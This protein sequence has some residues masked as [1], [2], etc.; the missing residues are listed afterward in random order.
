METNR[1]IF[2]KHDQATIDQ[3]DRCLA[4]ERAIAGA[5]CADGHLGYSMP[6]GGVVAYKDAVSPSGVGFDIA[7]GNK[8]VRTDI[9]ANEIEVE[10]ILREI[11]RRVAFGLGRK[12]PDPIE[13]PV[14]ELDERW[15]AVEE[16]DPSLRKRAREQLGTVGSGN[17]YVD[18]LSDEEG[19]LWIACH[20]GSRGFGHRIASGFLNLAAGKPF[21]ERIRESEEPAVLGMNTARGDLY[22]TLMGLAGEYAYAGRDLV[23]DQILEILD[24]PTVAESVHCHHNFAW[25]EDGLFV[26]RKGATPLTNE[27]AFIGGSMGDI[28]VVVRGTGEEIGAL[29]SAPHGAG[30]LISRTKAAGKWKKVTETRTRPDGSTHTFK[31]RVRDKSTALID[32]DKVKS[33]LSSRGITV[34]GAGADEAPAVYKDLASVLAQHPNIYV[35]HTL[36][37]IGVVMAGEDVFDPYKD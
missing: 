9:R 18:L 35:E 27:P 11:E 37:P 17:H 5:L 10:P 29:G 13:S 19:W 34:L 14:L 36:R 23:I 4:D 6:I 7:C 28:S 32:F 25:V 31:R 26:V 21:S 3:L 12:N 20:F 33:E 8:A 15:K 16:L 22:F 1:T 30:R 2:G 24:R